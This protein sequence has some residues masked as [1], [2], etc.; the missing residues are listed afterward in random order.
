MWI[1]K[2][3]ASSIVTKRLSRGSLRIWLNRV[4]P[5]P[6]QPLG[7]QISDRTL[8]HTSMRIIHYQVLFPLSVI[9]ALSMPVIPGCTW[10]L[11]R[12]LDLREIILKLVTAASIPDR[13]RRL[14][15]AQL[16]VLNRLD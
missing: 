13:D 8:T 5:T 12:P 11:V 4:F 16:V 1:L 15:L 9:L 6:L 10:M 14:I 2:L 3:W 7:D